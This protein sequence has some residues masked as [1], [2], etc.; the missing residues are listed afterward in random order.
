MN[1]QNCSPR[2]D[3]LALVKCSQEKGKP[4]NY[5]YEPINKIEAKKYAEKYAI[6]KGNLKP[7]MKSSNL[8]ESTKKLW[9]KLGNFFEGEMMYEKRQLGNQKP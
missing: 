3:L 8:E 2:R 5:D 4:Q 7:Q 6:L 9:E 1:V